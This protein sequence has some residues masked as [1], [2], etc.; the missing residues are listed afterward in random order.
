MLACL[1]DGCRIVA[2]ILPCVPVHTRRLA[3]SERYA[4]Q[5]LTLQGC[6]VQEG[7][8]PDELSQL[9]V[10]SYAAGFVP[11]PQRSAGRARQG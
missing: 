9:D 2:T 5:R 3:G 4:S 10:Q 6:G 8:G 1:P 11:S 7:L